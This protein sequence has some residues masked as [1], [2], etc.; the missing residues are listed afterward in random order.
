MDEKSKKNPIGNDE[1]RG[2]Y[3]DRQDIHG[4]Q[5]DPKNQD[6]DP[7]SIQDEPAVTGAGGWIRDTDEDLTEESV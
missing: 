7:N 6:S 4:G 1:S 3:G 5:P 2:G